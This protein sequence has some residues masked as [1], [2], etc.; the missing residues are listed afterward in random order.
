MNQVPG[1]ARCPGASARDVM[2]TD[3]DGAPATLLTESYR[4]LGDEDL[5]VSRYT[6]QDFYNAEINRVWSRTW[7]WACREEHV[8]EPGDYTVYDVGPYSVL[9][10]RQTNGSIK[11]FVNACPHRGMQFAAAGSSGKGKQFLRCPFHGMSW[12]LDGQLREIPCRWDFPHVQDQHFGLDEVRTG[13][14]GGFVFINL[15][16][17]APP[18]DEYLARTI[19]E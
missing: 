4:F 9:V 6:A 16:T 18:L 15:D 19:H 2:R 1:E 3:A 5:P 14:W 7:Q 10:V 13:L 17:A 12:T 8:P 11:A